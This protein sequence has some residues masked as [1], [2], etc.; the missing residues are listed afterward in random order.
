MRG[1]G[2]GKAAGPGFTGGM[3]DA[4]ESQALALVEDATLDFALGENAAAVAKLRAAVAAYPGSFEAWLALAEVCFAMRALDDALEAG[5]RALSLRR[6]DIHANTTL[7]RIWMER[8]DKPNAERY[9]AQ[10]RMLGW[11]AELKNPPPV[12]G[13]PKSEL[14]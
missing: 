4:A 3:H 11:K 8:G 5:E 6:D 10:A 12:P 13:A 9:G 2:V 7:S 14:G 1:F